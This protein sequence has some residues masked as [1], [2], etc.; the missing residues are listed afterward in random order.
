MFYTARKTPF[1]FK[2]LFRNSQFGL[3]AVVQ[4]FPKNV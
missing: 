4:R 3:R 2:Y 1:I